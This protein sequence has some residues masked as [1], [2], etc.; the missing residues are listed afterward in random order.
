MGNNCTLTALTFEWLFS[1]DLHVEAMLHRALSSRYFILH[2]PQMQWEEF[3][4]MELMT[5]CEIDF[6]KAVCTSHCGFHHIYSLIKES[7]EFTNNSY[8]GQLDVCQL[9]A[10]TLE[11]LGSNGNGTSLGRFA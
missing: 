2:H 5:M 8:C 6:K 10:I 7:P 9:L 1:Q 4:L 3:N 11:R